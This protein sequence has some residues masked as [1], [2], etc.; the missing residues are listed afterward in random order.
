MS[1]MPGCRAVKLVYDRGE[2]PF[3]WLVDASND[4]SIRCCVWAFELPEEAQSAQ[5]ATAKSIGL[6]API[7][8][9]LARTGFARH[10][11]QGSFQH[12]QAVVE[13]LAKDID[14]ELRANAR[15]FLKEMQL[16]GD[17]ELV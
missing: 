5:R 6:G 2:N 8:E 17:S 15:S 1:T 11:A 16:V 12:A 3:V 14:P 7:D 9:V 4:E 10:A 13:F